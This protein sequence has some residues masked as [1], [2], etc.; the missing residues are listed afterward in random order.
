MVVAQ[1]SAESLTT[2][3]RPVAGDDVSV[4]GFDEAIADALVRL[5]GVVV[6]YV[7]LKRA[8]EV[9]FAE[10]NDVIEALGAN[11]EHE[12]LGMGVQVRA[13]GRKA[14]DLATAVLQEPSECGGVDGI[15]VEDQGDCI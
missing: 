2:P 9:R 11:R 10:R 5:L 13:P 6:G 7:L 4:R 14:H 15:A 3:H 1:Q 8:P 12:A